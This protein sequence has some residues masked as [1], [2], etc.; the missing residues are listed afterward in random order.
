MRNASTVAVPSRPA[1]EL[2]GFHTVENAPVCDHDLFQISTRSI[3][4]NTGKKILM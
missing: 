4:L 3:L 2:L 1:E